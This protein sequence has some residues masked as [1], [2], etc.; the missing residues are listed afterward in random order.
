MALL[1]KEGVHYI[2]VVLQMPT[3]T[4]GHQWRYGVYK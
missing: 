3:L 1:K 4:N 2:S